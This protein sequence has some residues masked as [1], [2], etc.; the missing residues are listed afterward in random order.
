MATYYHHR[1]S[2]NPLK[3]IR[4]S[5]TV[6]GDPLIVKDREIGF[7]ATKKAISKRT[8]KL[9]GLTYAIY[10]DALGARVRSA[11]EETPSEVDL[12]TIG[13][14]FSWG[15]GIDQEQTFTHL[16][17]K[18]QNLSSANFAFG[19]YGTVQSLQLL[20]R[21]K[22][23][24]P[25]IVLYG[26]IED[27]LRRNLS[28]CAPN[29]SAY[30]L[31][32]AHV[33]FASGLNSPTLSPPH[34]EYF[35]P[36]LDRAYFEQ[37]IQNKGSAWNKII[38]QFKRDLYGLRFKRDVQYEATEEK[39]ASAYSFLFKQLIDVTSSLGAKLIVLSIPRLECE[40][41]TPAPPA[42]RKAADTHDT[43][44]LDSYPIIKKSCEAGKGAKL[45]LPNDAH[46][47]AYTHK[48]LAELLLNH[49]GKNGMFVTQ[50][51]Q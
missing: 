5:I 39:K 44:F 29:L 32:V 30:C 1:A 19:S 48:L 25:K 49:I 26:V 51:L 41:A 16:V 22:K 8:D 31:P 14:S 13:G 17:A 10:T 42:I 2:Q 24:N 36:D 6:E 34:L 38:W 43:L 28:P 7:V 27:H 15:H 47:S 20:N 46:P 9:S 37:V 3:G 33:T 45:I 40:R 4:S 35:S 11:T 50:R 23:L 12:M 21:H 18:T